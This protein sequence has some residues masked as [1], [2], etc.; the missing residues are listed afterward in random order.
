[1]H[2]L[3]IVEVKEVGGGMDLLEAIGAGAGAGGAVGAFGGPGT[4]AAG[5]LIGAI[6]GAI[7]Y[8]LP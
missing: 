7:V 5:M 2:E 1:M 6:A 8:E 3:S 4:A